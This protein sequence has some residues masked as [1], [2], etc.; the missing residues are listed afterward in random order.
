MD[1]STRDRGVFLF[2]PFRLDPVRRTLMRDGVPVSL[3]PR[4]FDT[5]LHL[6]ANHE[7]LVEKSELLAAVW[8]RRNVEE[9][10]LSQA[11]FGLR[12]VLQA[13]GG[14]DTIIVTAPG[15]GYRCGVPVVFETA[16]QDISAAMFGLSETSTPAADSATKSWWRR[17]AAVTI[18]ALTILLAAA[19]VVV[20]EIRF[21]A[22]PNASTRAALFA[23]PPHS[24]A[25]LAFSNL[26][27]DPG[28]EY[29]SDGISEELIDALGRI[30]DIRVAARQSSFSFKGK[31]AT[32]AEIAR[33]LN[34][35]TVLEGSV[36]R[37]G[38]RLRVT[39]QLIDAA[40]GYQLWSDHYDKA[41]GDSFGLQAEIAGAVIASLRTSVLAKDVAKLTLG[42]TKDPAAFD[43]Y[44]RGVTLGSTFTAASAKQ[45]AAA[46][47]EAILKDPHFA[48]ALTRHADME[49]SI[50]EYFPEDDGAASERTRATALTEARR[51]VELAPELGMAHVTLGS[52][53]LADWDFTGAGQ[54]IRARQGIGAGRC[55]SKS[56]MGSFSVRFGAQGG[57]PGGGAAEC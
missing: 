46:Y 1:V 20:W 35:A 49:L 48:L 24:V 22:G 33:L 53:L 27:G 37:D 40:T 44:L 36:R 51:A 15:R 34:V 17:T 9:A 23:P 55:V 16:A 13:G 45:A 6:V 3:A 2:G 54:R 8:G 32:I 18:A 14:E 31:S 57:G 50:A 29:F 26:S 38:A 21:S 56:Q 52:I 28:Q 11:I 43:A 10:N 4:L 25:V 7:R 19:C 30:G 47:E 12:K 5:L 39:T 41:L 42:G